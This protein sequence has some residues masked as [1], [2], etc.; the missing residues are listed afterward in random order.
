HQTC[1]EPTRTEMPP[2]GREAGQLP[3]RA[4]FKLG[5][6]GDSPAP[7]GDPPTGTAES[8]L[9]KSAS[10]LARTVA[11]IPSGESPDGTGGSPVL[12]K[13]IFQT[14][15]KMNRGANK[16]PIPR[17]FPARAAAAEPSNWSGQ[18]LVPVYC[19]NHSSLSVS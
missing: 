14:R 10:L 8:N 15:S 13:T 17:S 5:S 18:S 3:L 4:R 2:V 11:P 7:V 9:G 6:A 16:F 12:P 1:R 19:W